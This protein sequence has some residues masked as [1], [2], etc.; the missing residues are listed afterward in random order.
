MN[1]VGVDG[2]KYGWVTASYND[3]AVLLFKNIKDVF[4]HY[5][6]DAAFFIDIPIGL[7]STAFAIRTCEK[8]TRAILPA[9]RKSSV[10]SI[11]CRE[12][13]TAKTY[14]EANKVNRNV[15][16]CGISKQTWFIM[17]KIKQ[18]DDVLTKDYDLRNQIKES[19]PEIAF[20]FL[21]KGIPLA[22]S[23]KTLEGIA[24]RLDILMRHDERSGVFF[25]KA[26]AYYKRGD[27][28]KDDIADALCLALIIKC[29]NEQPHRYKKGS[30]SSSPLQDEYSIEMAIYYCSVND[31]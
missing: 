14:A 13:L 2:C 29:I 16:G 1:A 21:N 18:L 25:K 23:K 7:A 12:A 3:G 15:L 10:F 9:K 31:S 11:P 28:A 24:E 4:D 19:H 30:F 26:I 5:G 27:V 22:H 8:T 6:K 17:P 20:Q